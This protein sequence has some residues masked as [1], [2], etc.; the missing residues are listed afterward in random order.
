MT[1]TL[2]SASWKQILAGALDITKPKSIN[3]ELR[4]SNCLFNDCFKVSRVS[5]TNLIIMIIMQ[6]WEN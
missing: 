3:L 1:V 6:V 5:M 2:W 4:T